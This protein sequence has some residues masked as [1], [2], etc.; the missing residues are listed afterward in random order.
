MLFYKLFFTFL[1]FNFELSV[2]CYNFSIKKALSRLSLLTHDRKESSAYNEGEQYQSVVFN[3]ALPSL[4]Q[5]L[6]E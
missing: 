4:Y 3:R 2:N 1:K 5:K 6:D